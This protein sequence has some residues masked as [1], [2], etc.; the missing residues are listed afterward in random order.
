MF[1]SDLFWYRVPD[2]YKFPRVV[3][4]VVC[5][6]VVVLGGVARCVVVHCCLADI[7]V[8]VLWSV[9]L[10]WLVDVLV[11]FCANSELVEVGYA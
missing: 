9:F 7:V 1:I 5:G 11:H 10:C 8:V 3:F 6:V 2:V 4:H